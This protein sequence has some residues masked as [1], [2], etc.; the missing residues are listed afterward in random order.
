[1][2]YF[3]SQISHA[4]VLLSQYCEGDKIEK[5]EMDGTCSAY[6]GGERRI[7]ILVGEPEG[8]RPLG[9]LRCRWKN[10]IKMDLQYVRCGDMDWIELAQDRG[11]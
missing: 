3:H 11:R 9:R 2:F 6:G 5:N 7:Q 1:V 8:R 10:N 4:S